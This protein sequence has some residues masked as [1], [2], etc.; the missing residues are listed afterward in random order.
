MTALPF[1]LILEEANPRIPARRANYA[2]R[3]A[4]LDYVLGAIPRIGKVLDGFLK[5]LGFAFHTSSILSNGGFVK[6]IIAL[7]SGPRG[8]QKWGKPQDGCLQ[9]ALSR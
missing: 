3:P 7:V 4:T 6:L 8:S 2:I 9:N 5:G 1:V